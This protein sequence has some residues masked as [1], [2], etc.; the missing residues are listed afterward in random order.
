MKQKKKKKLK[1]EE[2]D[3]LFILKH[4]EITTRTTTM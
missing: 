3:L 2:I 4:Q 1:N